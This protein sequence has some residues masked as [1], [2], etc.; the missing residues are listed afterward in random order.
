MISDYH[1]IPGGITSASGVSDTTRSLPCFDHTHQATTIPLRIVEVRSLA[2]PNHQQQAHSQAQQ[3]PV[4]QELFVN[5][6]QQV[7]SNNLEEPLDLSVKN[8][9]SVQAEDGKGEAET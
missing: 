4:Q 1:W 2:T 3:A 9:G 6:A 7:P 8:T 5:C